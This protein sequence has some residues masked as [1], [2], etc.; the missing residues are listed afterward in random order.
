MNILSAIS[1]VVNGGANAVVFG[2]NGDG[3]VQICESGGNGDIHIETDAIVTG[4][5]LNAHGLYETDV[6][7]PAAEVAAMVTGLGATAVQSVITDW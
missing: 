1:A 2:C 4:W 3:L 7:A 6:S 5:H